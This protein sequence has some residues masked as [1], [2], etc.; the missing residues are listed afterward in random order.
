[1]CESDP[2]DE[3]TMWTSAGAVALGAVEVLASRDA[4]ASAKAAALGRRGRPQSLEPTAAKEGALLQ[5]GE[6]VEVGT[7]CAR[8]RS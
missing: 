4:D 6:A 8:G 2:G 1:M 3:T 7:L 5:S